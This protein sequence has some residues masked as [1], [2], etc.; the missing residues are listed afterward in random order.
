MSAI[1]ERGETKGAALR[2]ENLSVTL[3]DGTVVV[4]EAEV[5]IA[6]GEKVLVVGE[7]GTGK[8][9]LVR[10]I[11]GL[12][13]WGEGKLL[14]K[15]GARL[16]MLP[17]RPYIPIGTLRRAI[18]YPSAVEDVP[19]DEVAKAM[20]DVGLDHLVDALDEEKPWDQTLSGGEKQRVAF[21]RVLVQEPDIIVMDEGTS[22][23]DPKSQELLMNLVAGA[24]AQDDDHQRRPPA[25]AGEIPSAQARAGS[26]PGG[27]QARARYRSAGAAEAAMALA[28]ARSQGS[29]QG[30]SSGL[31]R[32]RRHARQEPIGV[33]FVSC[34]GCPA[35]RTGFAG[36]LWE[37]DM[38]MVM[39]RCPVTG[40]RVSTGIETVPD[41]VNLIPPI[42]A[43]LVC[44]D[45]GGVHVW[46]I[47][48]AELVNDHLEELDELPRPW[49]AQ[50][51][52]LIDPQ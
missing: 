26:P 41:S 25:G 17:Q 39:I 18:S 14:L 24:V 43:R 38:A 23:L 8:S 27:R 16:F 37:A 29:G 19:K 6:P 48:E 15:S 45:C 30:Q 36:D 28:A 4:N 51:A 2:L 12:W 49:T 32:W 44:P 1:I 34:G 21:A 9:S 31:A 20:K 52:K 10:A 5:E 35:A 13:P 46:S 40:Q 22:A 11:A 7:S 50:L 33:S 42:N 3:D 47:L